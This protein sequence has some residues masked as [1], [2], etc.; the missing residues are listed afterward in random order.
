MG[1]LLL[2][3][4]SECALNLLRWSAASEH[5]YFTTNRF[6]LLLTEDPGDIDLLEDP[7]IFIPRIVSCGSFIMKTLATSLAV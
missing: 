7:E 6:W 1:I 2:E 5:N 4:S 3:F